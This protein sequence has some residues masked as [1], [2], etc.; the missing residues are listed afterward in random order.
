MGNVPLQ[1]VQLGCEARPYDRG[2][3]AQR[4]CGGKVRSFGQGG[5]ETDSGL[6]LFLL[7]FNIGN[8]ASQMNP[9]AKRLRKIAVPFPEK[10]RNIAVNFRFPVRG[11]GKRLFQRGHQ[12]AGAFIEKVVPAAYG[13]NDVALLSCK[14]AGGRNGVGN[15]RQFPDD[16]FS[17]EPFPICNG[18]EGC[19][20]GEGDHVP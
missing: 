18:L 6:G 13:H 1:A 10:V 5:A 8:I 17:I 4:F 7:Q 15:Q 12:Q 19:R 3:G 14:A 20:N 9:G 11:V 16:G 2:P